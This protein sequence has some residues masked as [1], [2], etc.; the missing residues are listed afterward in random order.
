ML[1]I[2]VF[3]NFDAIHDYWHDENQNGYRHEICH[4]WVQSLGFWKM[5]DDGCDTDQTDWVQ[6][7]WNYVG[8]VYSQTDVLLLLWYLDHQRL[9]V[10]A[11]L[12]FFTGATF[13][14]YTVI[15]GLLEQAL[16][17]IIIMELDAP[18]LRRI[19]PHLLICRSLLVLNGLI[20][21]RPSSYERKGFLL[22]FPIVFSNQ[23][24]VQVQSICSLR[25]LWHQTLGFFLLF[26]HFGKFFGEERFIIWF[27]E[28]A[29]S[30]RPW[31]GDIRVLLQLADEGPGIR[32][33]DGNRIPWF[34]IEFAFA[35]EIW[36]L[37][38]CVY[39]ADV[40]KAKLIL[41]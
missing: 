21:Q 27:G 6:R 37:T 20:L 18:F 13:V 14:P 34:L 38:F 40:L 23:N 35:H 10:F 11:T 30:L 31:L 22:H 15:R 2:Q 24:M 4:Y 1:R 36:Y 41:R 9:V 7:I 8:S 26:F 16:F 3:Q 12:R 28:R 33:F 5:G 17:H 29:V 19:L 25:I 39:L 32:V